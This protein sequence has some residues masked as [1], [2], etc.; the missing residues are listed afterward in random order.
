MNPLPKSWIRPFF[1]PLDTRKQQIS[2]CAASL[3]AV[4]RVVDDAADPI[5][6]SAGQQ[7]RAA[8]RAGTGLGRE[9]TTT[10]Y[11]TTRI[12]YYYQYQRKFQHRG[13]TCVQRSAAIFATRH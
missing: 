1:L 3:T 8:L 11:T 12:Y 5:V 9:R 10:L 4:R 2:Y 6:T 13:T 7:R